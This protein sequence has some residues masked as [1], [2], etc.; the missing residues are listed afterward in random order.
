MARIFGTKPRQLH[1]KAL[2]AAETSCT[3]WS[4]MSSYFCSTGPYSWSILCGSWSAMSRSRAGLK[5]SAASNLSHRSRKP[6]STRLW[7]AYSTLHYIT[8]HYIALQCSAVQCLMLHYIY[9]TLHQ[10]HLRYIRTHLNRAVYL[11]IYPSTYL[12][13]HPPLYLSIN[14]SLLSTYLSVWLSDYMSVHF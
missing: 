7:H 4:R 12:C 8:L 11:S 14:T 6:P 1:W 3:K 2:T 13:I 10:L 5:Q 9:T